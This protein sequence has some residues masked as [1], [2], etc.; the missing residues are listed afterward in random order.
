M[1]GENVGL[2][3]NDLMHWVAY[4]LVCNEEQTQI[5]HDRLRLMPM[6]ELRTI[7]ALAADPSKRAAVLEAL[8][9]PE[10]PVPFVVPN[11]LLASFSS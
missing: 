3:R 11:Q 2:S 6:S 7:D 10:A 8:L 5:V 4:W 1:N 9:S